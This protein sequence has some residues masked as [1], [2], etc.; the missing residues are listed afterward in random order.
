MPEI[1]LKTPSLLMPVPVIFIF[2]SATVI[3]PCI[4]KAA[5]FNTVVA[6]S[7]VPSALLF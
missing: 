2:A 7:V 3:P 6:T 1:F 4:C 5:L